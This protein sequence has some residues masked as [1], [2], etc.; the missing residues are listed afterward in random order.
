VPLTGDGTAVGRSSWRE[1]GTVEVAEGWEREEPANIGSFPGEETGSTSLRNLGGRLDR[2]S[3]GNYEMERCILIRGSGQLL[4]ESV[5]EMAHK[6][7]RCAWAIIK[8]AAACRN[9][10]VGRNMGSTITLEKQYV[11]YADSKRKKGASSSVC[12]L[13]HNHT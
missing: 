12:L 3:R 13:H 10:R 5:D 4:L 6:F 1:L 7:R 2:R 8:A 11:R 9:G